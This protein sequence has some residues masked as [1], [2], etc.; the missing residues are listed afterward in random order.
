MYKFDEA[1]GIKAAVQKYCSETPKADRS[2][3][4]FCSRGYNSLNITSKQFND[5]KWYYR[6]IEGHYPETSGT[7]SEVPVQAAEGSDTDS[8]VAEEPEVLQVPERH[9]VEIDGFTVGVDNDFRVTPEYMY[10]RYNQFNARYF[11]DELPHLSRSKFVL[12]NARSFLG[13]TTSRFHFFGN[14]ITDFEIIKISLSTYMGRSE[15]TYCSTLLHEMIHVYEVAVLNRKPGHGYAFIRKMEEINSHGPWKVST[16]ETAEERADRGSLDAT[17]SHRITNKLLA[18]IKP[19]RG[20][21]GFILVPKTID[22]NKVAHL[23]GYVGLFKVNDAAPF[24][25]VPSS[26]LSGYRFSYKP[27][28]EEDFEMYKRTGVIENIE[29]PETFRERQLRLYEEVVSQIEGDDPDISVKKIKKLND[30]EYWV[31]MEII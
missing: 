18:V 12:S 9:E 20:A 5:N 11:A 15:K 22:R 2:F 31:E 10:T 3:S 26:T 24:A 4:D 30:D 23:P 28:S 29:H 19:S 7:G 6:D 1:S 14:R 21:Y 27:A 13:Q 16:R 25:L 17:V 8:P